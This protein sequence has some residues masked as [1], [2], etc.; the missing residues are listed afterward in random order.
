MGLEDFLPRWFTSELMLA[1]GGSL[2]GT[3][4][5][6]LHSPHVVNL[7]FSQHGDWVLRRC[8]PKAHIPR[9]QTSAFTKLANIPLAKASC[10]IKARKLTRW[11]KEGM[12]SVMD[13]IIHDSLV[14]TKVRFTN[15]KKSEM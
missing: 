14:A 9:G 10:V 8:I 4:S 15:S 11:K 12:T 7:I 5:E 13:D 1:V 2:T 3:L 6:D